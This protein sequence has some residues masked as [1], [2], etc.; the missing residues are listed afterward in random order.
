[1]VPKRVPVLVLKIEPSLL[2][3]YKDGPKAMSSFW[4]M[5]GIRCQLHRLY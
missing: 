4:F 5:V 3:Y 2:F 1:M